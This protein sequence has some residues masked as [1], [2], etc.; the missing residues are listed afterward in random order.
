MFIKKSQKPI[1]KREWEG[2]NYLLSHNLTLNILALDINC[3]FPKESLVH[4]RSLIHN[5]QAA[6]G[7]QPGEV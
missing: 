2:A 6:A 5:I 3:T 1:E 7:L 4:P